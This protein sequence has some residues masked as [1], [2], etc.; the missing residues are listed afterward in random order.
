MP[1]KKNRS[2]KK[3]IDD[4]IP[5]QNDLDDET[6]DNFKEKLDLED[7]ETEK[8]GDEIEKSESSKKT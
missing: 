7:Q 1:K 3:E 5:K 2:T 8:G 4:D 6:I